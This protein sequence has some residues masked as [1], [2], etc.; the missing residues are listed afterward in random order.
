MT[1][2]PFRLAMVSGAVERTAHPGRLG[3]AVDPANP[4]E[5]SP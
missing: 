5:Q 2:A 1:K 3:T 4:L